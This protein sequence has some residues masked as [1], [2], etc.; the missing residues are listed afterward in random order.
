MHLG[1]YYI[2]FKSKEFNG[3]EDYCSKDRENI[4][5][6]AIQVLVTGRK[7]DICNINSCYP[8]V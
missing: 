7:F 1:S 6:R 2:I 4:L 8:G 5:L 3:E